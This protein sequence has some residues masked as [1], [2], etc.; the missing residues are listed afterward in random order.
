MKKIFII[1]LAV[2][3]VLLLAACGGEKFDFELNENGEAVLVAYRGKGGEVSV[4]SEWQGAPVT[5]VGDF[6]FAYKR[7]VTS[8]TLPE[9]VS[10]IGKYAFV[11]CGRLG[12]IKIENAKPEIEKG[13]FSECR[14]LESIDLKGCERIPEDAFKNCISLK[15]VSFADAKSVENRA[16]FGCSSLVDLYVPDSVVSIGDEVFKDCKSLDIIEF[17]KNIS[18]IGAYCFDGVDGYVSFS[19]SALEEIKANTFSG[20]SCSVAIPASVKSIEKGA[21]SGC[22]AEIVFDENVDIDVT[23][24]MFS[25]Y[26]GDKLDLPRSIKNIGEK[27]FENSSAKITLAEGIESIG[28]MA[29]YGYVGDEL[30]IPASVTYVGQQAFGGASVAIRFAEGSRLT[31]L[32]PKAFEKWQGS[33]IALPEGL[34]SIGIAAFSGCINLKSITIPEGVKVIRS[35]TFE[36]CR[37]LVS[38]ELN[39]VTEIGGCAFI[40]CSLLETVEL[41]DKVESIGDM[42]FGVCISLKNVTIGKGV[43]YI[44]EQ[45]FAECAALGSINYAGSKDSWEKITLIGGE[46]A[47]GYCK[48]EFAE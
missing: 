6:A 47:I 4:P 21:F 12:E 22:S 40:G 28:D 18:S 27:A 17:G 46:A 2:V 5:A 31:S 24:G 45:A 43:T 1:C 10:Y 20:L 9:T 26:K 41:S 23:A 13:A 19:G 30:V 34:E 7:S 14:G 37:S 39:N 8:V 11:G 15:E 25:G 29:F 48:V 42:A 16:F 38:V 44:G 32:G 35:S 36:N 3:T 33:E